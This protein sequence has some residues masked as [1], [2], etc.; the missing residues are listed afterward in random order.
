[1]FPYDYALLAEIPPKWCCVLLSMHY[2]LNKKENTVKK[3]VLI[4]EHSSPCLP[5]PLPTSSEDSTGTMAMLYSSWH[6]LQY[7]VLIFLEHLQVCAHFLFFR[8][9]SFICQTF[10]EHSSVLSLGLDCASSIAD[11]WIFAELNDAF[12]PRPSRSAQ[13]SRG[14]FPLQWLHSYSFPLLSLSLCY[15]IKI[16]CL[17]PDLSLNRLRRETTHCGSP[18]PRTLG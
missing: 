14:V 3:K 8:F 1:M 4:N 7:L 11:D 13:P 16:I 17:S 15:S 5:S 18:A 6:F 10:L 9:I 12:L 2:F